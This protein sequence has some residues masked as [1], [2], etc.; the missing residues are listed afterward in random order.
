[1]PQEP[2][3]S[4]REVTELKTAFTNLNVE[5]EQFRETAKKRIRLLSKSNRKYRK[6]LTKLSKVILHGQGQQPSV[7]LRLTR[8][9]DRYQELSKHTDATTSAK[10]MTR[11]QIVAA[12][13]GFIISSGLT[14]IAIIMQK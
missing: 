6:V 14:I 1:M 11:G 5:F 10:I 4:S 13:V 8:V 3:H 12:I 7:M 2:L 9:E